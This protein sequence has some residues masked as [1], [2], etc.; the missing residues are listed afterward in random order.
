[1]PSSR[2]RCWARTTSTS[3]H[4]SIQPRRPTSWP[5]PWRELGRGVSFADLENASAVLLVC[6]EPEEEAGM[7]FLRLRKAFRKKSLT[8]W[9]LAPYASNGARKMGAQLIACVPGD[10]AA[11]L[12]Q[13]NAE[14][15]TAD[16]RLAEVV[17]DAN[18]VILVGERA[19]GLSGTFSACLR[20]AERTGARLAWVPRR[21]G[22]RGAVEA[23]CLPTLLPGG[24][25]V[26]DA[27]ARVDT[28][29]TWGV[30]SLPSWKVATP[31]RS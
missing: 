7:I 30:E 15:G 10:E 4:A 16:Q 2:V 20:L 23:G 12:D 25:P 8:S 19:A 24:R 18:S 21:A 14:G 3:G 27:A 13:V 5:T 28:Q 29:A 26:S 9:T 11:I 22:D 6:L 1:M 31:T 17:L